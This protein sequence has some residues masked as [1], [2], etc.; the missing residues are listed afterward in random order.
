MKPACIVAYR[1]M[2]LAALL[3]GSGAIAANYL[4]IPQSTLQSVVPGS[5]LNKPTLVPGFEMRTTPVSYA[6]YAEFLRASPKWQ[7]TAIPALFADELY[8]HRWENAT[9]PGA[10][11]SPAQEVTSVSWFAAQAYCASEHARLPNWAEWELVAAADETHADARGDPAWRARIL[12]WYAAPANASAIPP[13]SPPNYYGIR[14]MHGVIWEW[15]NDFNALLISAD[16]RVQGSADKLQFCGAGADNLQ[17]KENYAVL[18]RVALLSSLT[19]ASTTDNL[20]FRCA[21]SPAEE[22]K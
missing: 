18:M 4:P 10:W 1:S 11:A 22:K 21:R 5:V 19:G 13:D 9:E 12:S 14:D 15:V 3:A 6:E 20:G 2:L 7:R 8:L 17:F 16:S